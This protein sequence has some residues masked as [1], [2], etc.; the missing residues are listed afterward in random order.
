MMIHAWIDGN[1]PELARHF[2]EARHS[3]LELQLTKF[4]RRGGRDLAPILWRDEC[5][6]G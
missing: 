6:G 1:R 5:H 4:R 2:D 3:D